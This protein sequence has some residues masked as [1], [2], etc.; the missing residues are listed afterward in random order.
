MR[1]GESFTKLRELIDIID[2]AVRALFN[3]PV[4]LK[5][6]WYSYI[7]HEYRRIEWRKKESRFPRVAELPSSAFRISQPDLYWEFSTL[8]EQAEDSMNGD[9]DYAESDKHQGGHYELG[10]YDRFKQLVANEWMKLFKES[11]DKVFP[12]LKMVFGKAWGR[13]QYN[14]GGDGTDFHIKGFTERWFWEQ[15]D[16]LTRC[17]GFFNWLWENYRSY[18]GF[19]SFYPEREVEY[20]ELCIKARN[21]DIYRKDACEKFMAIVLQYRLFPNQE[22][23]DEFR[24]EFHYRVYEDVDFSGCFEWHEAKTEELRR[25][26]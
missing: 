26:V 7:V 12:E 14:Y 6:W 20:R 19:I 4:S 21:K 17:D 15:T 18:D 25:T 10:H 8:S 22:T 23:R 13:E 3:K 16:A 1:S 9:M 11:L 2:D 24:N 5:D